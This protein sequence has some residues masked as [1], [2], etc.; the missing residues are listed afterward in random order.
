MK[1]RPTIAAV[2]AEYNPFHNGHS[3]LIE[4]AKRKTGAEK[5]IIIMSGDFVQRGEPAIADKYDRA[6]TAC[7]NGADAVFLMPFTASISSAAD[8]AYGGIQTANAFGCIDHLVFGAENDDISVLS[9]AAEDT[10]AI[11]EDPELQ[12]HLSK[13]I[14]TGKTY[15]EAMS[16]V[17]ANSKRTDSAD[18]LRSPNNTLA[19]NYLIALKKTNSDITPVAVKRKGA[20]HNDGMDPQTSTASATS[21]RK[22]LRGNHISD[23]LDVIPGE[24]AEILATY[25]NGFISCNDLSNMLFYRLG[26]FMEES[27]NKA[28]FSKK[29]SIYSDMTDA[30][31]LRLYSKYHEAYTWDELAAAVWAKNL[32]YSRIDR[33]LLHVLFNITDELKKNLNKESTAGYLRPLAINRDSI[34]LLT[35]IKESGKA[36]LITRLSDAKELKENAAKDFAKSLTAADIYRRIYSIEHSH[37]CH[38]EYGRDFM[39]IL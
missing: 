1:K 16:M 37:E 14:S 24:M 25:R 28:D 31:A 17:M 33:T 34:D 29:M 5:L 18:C 10:L 8:F 35:Y 39:I 26:Q 19:V 20:G 9:K 32:T 22:A 21:I 38:D 15:P 4:E 23:I 2:I 13:L 11:D 30:L 3:Y 6:Y 7:R 27:F 12:K 36:P